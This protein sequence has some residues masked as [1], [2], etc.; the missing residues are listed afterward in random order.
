MEKLEENFEAVIDRA[1]DYKES[2]ERQGIKQSDVDLLREKTKRS[3]L[4]PRWIHDK[5][6]RPA[7]FRLR[8]TQTKN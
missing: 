1:F 4:V 6:V 2:M 3:K 8:R 7:F 5:Q